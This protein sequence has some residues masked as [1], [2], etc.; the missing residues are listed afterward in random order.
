MPSTIITK[1]SITASAVPV[2]GDLTRGELALNLTDGRIY[3]RDEG[4]TIVELGI[5]PSTIAITAGT[6]NN[7][8]IGATTAVAGTFTNLTATGTL[9]GTLATDAQPNITSLGTIAALVAGTG[10]F[11]TSLN[12]DGTATMDG[13]ISS[14]NVGIG[15]DTP[16]D[17]LDTP[18]I[19]IGGSS[20]SGTY[21]ASALFL[22]NTSGTTRFFSTGSNTTTQGQ[23]S[24]SGVSSNG[25]LN[26]ERMRIDSSGNVLV[27]KATTA[28]NTEGCNFVAGGHITKN[29]AN[30]FN[31]NR[32]GDSGALVSFQQAGGTVGSISVTGSTTAYNTS[33]DYRLKDITG[34]LQGSGAYIDSLNPVEGT[35]KADGSVFVGLIAHEA[36]E[37]SRT[38][39]ATGEKD[40]EEMQGMS[41]SSSE[42]MANIL[43][44]LQSLRKRVA[45][46]EV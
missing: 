19:A 14:G 15:T 33:S 26:T 7:A 35:W 17:K 28:F 22:D 24:F 10:Q 9:T 43:A 20:I 25:S 41:Y 45:E 3:S 2:S 23:F 11:S 32:T 37:V 13:L 4:T 6:I 42:M 8:V 5:N 27:G 16:S 1:N 29:L 46:L 12:V 44:E 39:I 40:G 34:S 21:R 18:N 31:F 30:A 38:S 36:D